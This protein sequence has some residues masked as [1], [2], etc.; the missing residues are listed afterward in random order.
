[1]EYKNNWLILKYLSPFIGIL[2]CPATV[3][4]LWVIVSEPVV[5]SDIDLVEV[6]EQ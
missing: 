6:I 1:M 5:E 2:F 3:L 4:F